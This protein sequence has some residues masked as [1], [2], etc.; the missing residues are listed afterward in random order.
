MS[1]RIDSAISKSKVPKTDNNSVINTW[2]CFSTRTKIKAWHI[3]THCS[4]RIGSNLVSRILALNLKWYK[5]IHSVA[6]AHKHTTMDGLMNDKNIDSSVWFI[7]PSC[8]SLKNYPFAH[9]SDNVFVQLFFFHSFYAI[10]CMS[11]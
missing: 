5:I 11:K 4:Y 7:F 8:H 10:T 6:S 2:K 3:Q 1:Y 9:E